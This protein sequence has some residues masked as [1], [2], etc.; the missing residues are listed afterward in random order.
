MILKI[1]W[2]ENYVDVFKVVKIQDN[3]KVLKSEIIFEI[4]SDVLSD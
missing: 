4:N 3:Q 1:L 2:H